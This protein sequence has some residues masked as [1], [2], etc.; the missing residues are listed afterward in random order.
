MLAKQFVDMVAPGMFIGSPSGAVL[1]SP[2]F[3]FLSS[4]PL[5]DIRQVKDALLPHGQL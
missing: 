3:A 5:S 1:L 4:T 2:S